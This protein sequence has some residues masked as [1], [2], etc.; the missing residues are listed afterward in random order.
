MK[1]YDKKF[2][3]GLDLGV[4]SVGWS[5]ME[6]NEAYEPGRMIAANSH[7]FPA[8]AG[9]LEERRVA[10]GSR[11]LTRRRKNRLKAVRNLFKKYGYLNEESIRCFNEKIKD[12]YDDVYHLKVKGLSEK[13]D[14]NE[15]YI[16]LTHYAKHRGFKSNRK[17]KGTDKKEKEDDKLLLSAIKTTEAV[18]KDKNITIS[19]YI[20]SDDQFQDRIKN[21]TGEYKIGITR[22]MIEEEAARLL[23][24]QLSLGIITEEFKDNYMSLLTFQRSFSSGPDEPSPYHDP[25]KKMIGSC[26]YD[27]KLRAPVTAPS[28]ELFNLLQ[29]LI[30]V[31]YK[32]LGHIG[33]CRLEPHEIEQ[34]MKKTIKSKKIKYKEIEKIIGKSVMFYNEQ[35]TKDDYKNIKKNAEKNP[36][37][38]MEQV[39]DNYRGEKVFF[40]MK[41]YKYLK[42]QFKKLDIRCDDFLVF[43][44]I[45]DLLSKYKSDEDIIL[46]ID[47][48][49]HLKDKDQLFRNTILEFDVGKFKKFGKMSFSVIYDAIP[50]LEKGMN[51]SDAL[52][53]CHYHIQSKKIEQ[54]YQNLPPIFT[55]MGELNQTITNR[56][57]LA[58]LHATKQIV[59]AIMNRYGRPYAIHVEMARELS[60]SKK[61]RDKIYVEQMDRQID[62]LK[63]K[64][65]M[66]SKFPHVFSSVSD[67][68]FADIEKYTL[69]LEQNGVDPYMLAETGDV[70]KAKIS[71]K[72]LF[73]HEYEVDHILPY[74]KSFND[75][76]YNKVVVHKSMNQ[77]KGN[78]TPFEVWGNS[79]GYS[80]YKNVVNGYWDQKK[81]MYLIMEKIPQDLQ[82]EFSA[83]AINDTRYAT[84]EFVKIL[85]YYFPDIIVR[86]FTGQITAKLKGIWG[87]NNITHSYQSPVYVLNEEHD[88][89]IEAAMK[90]LAELSSENPNG[91]AAVECKKKIRKL[92]TERKE[93]NR[94]NHLHHALDATII[95]CA[96]DTLRRRVEVHEQY[97]RQKTQEEV[98]LK[99]PRF[100]AETGELIDYE[101][102]KIKRI[103]E[104]AYFDLTKNIDKHH[105]PLPYLTF[106][107]EVKAR[108]FERD[109]A[110]MRQ[111][112]RHFV[113]YDTPAIQDAKV[114]LV[115]EKVDKKVHGRLHEAT[116]FGV[117]PHTEEKD[118]I[119][120][121]QRKSIIDKSFDKKKLEN[122]YDKEGT[123]SQIYQ[124]VSDWLEGYQNG[125][126]AFEARNCYPKSKNGNS[127]K[128]IKIDMDSPK[129]EICIHPDKNQYVAKENVQ[130]IHVYQKDGV[131]FYTGMDPYRLLNLDKNP[132]IFLWY[133]VN[134]YHKVSYNEIKKQYQFVSKFHK[135]QIVKVVLKNGKS[136]YAKIHG[137][138]GGKIEFSS[139][140]GDCY[141]LIHDGLL[142]S[143]N[144]CRISVNQ[145]E[146][147]LICSVSILGEVND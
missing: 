77:K 2:I 55:A 130:Q 83:R 42:S 92:E 65:Q 56:C 111:T 33:E 38:S 21:T 127:I 53:T 95:A 60:K 126:A 75:R 68:R 116:I 62:K 137:F 80:K 34:I 128:K 88:K 123:Q 89:A 103:D 59:N 14:Y 40:E 115:T 134:K 144:R 30:N 73:S 93:K 13:L 70:N 117:A 136:G 20:I 57:V 9:D 145:V 129:E 106:T 90:E 124:A 49:E 39:R 135:N 7:V 109:E 66:C 36:S 32:E 133:G 15:L 25:L 102:L 4:G 91:I 98:S 1:Q 132:D 138:S 121:T 23:D 76:K 69:F 84:K 87:L 86:S 52:N 85:K 131:T 61:E 24:Q 46:H 82:K 6:L 19:Q 3:L 94:E 12:N 8:E 112:L 97:L 100:D 22:A 108:I 18:L 101:K 11:R 139:I 26:I 114:L 58:T 47:D 147:L 146:C 43:D 110:T 113:N 50:Y 74:S 120:L 119:V 78:R 45:A 16:C 71:E 17:N 44:D 29:S 5:C 48:Y 35:L 79:I 64:M 63:T 10:R 37:L 41:S 28:Y 143:V 140:L 122:I 54:E 96:T 104:S 31:R 105:F 125:Q 99:L 72:D 81:R 27:G 67:I 141:D 118:T 142:K 107:E 51:L